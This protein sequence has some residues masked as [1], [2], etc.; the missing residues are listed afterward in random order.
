MNSVIQ[1][2]LFLILLPCI[3]H[4]Q[5]LDPVFPLANVSEVKFVKSGGTEKIV[6]YD[7][8]G[9][10]TKELVVNDKDE[11]LSYAFY[12]YDKD[13]N[14]LLDL[15]ASTLGGPDFHI[16]NYDE[17]M[18]I[19]GAYGSYNGFKSYSKAL[20]KF[21][22]KSSSLEDVLATK[23]VQELLNGQIK[24]NVFTELDSLNRPLEEYVTIDNK[25]HEKAR[26]EYVENGGFV[27]YRYDA[28]TDVLSGIEKY[29]KS[30]LLV[31]RSIL[32]YHQVDDVFALPDSTVYVY[33]NMSKLKSTF[34]Y[35]G[36]NRR[37]SEERTYNDIG[38]LLAIYKYHK[39]GNKS[40]VVKYDYSK[41]GLMVITEKSY[42]ALSRQLTSTAVKEYQLEYAEVLEN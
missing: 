15:R 8:L 24:Y 27:K 31:K 17:S 36:A 2:M 3:V 22:Q 26:Y 5:F 13:H 41:N 37:L 6:S 18:L 35:Y 1:L 12:Q 7:S 33:N 14:L 23:E 9:Y 28:Q 38:N 4:A 30:K 32:Q 19:K 34:S 29:N 40:K 21:L 20:M 11:V 10:V 16:F 39:N 42:D 25:R